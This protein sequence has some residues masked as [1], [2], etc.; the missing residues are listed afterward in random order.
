LQYQRWRDLGDSNSEDL[1]WDDLLRQCKENRLSVKIDQHA[2]LRDKTHN[3]TL[4]TLTNSKR[5]R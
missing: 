2:P 1:P 5:P 4:E 3:L